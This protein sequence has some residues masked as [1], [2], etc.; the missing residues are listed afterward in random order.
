MKPV[1]AIIAHI[2]NHHGGLDQARAPQVA[3]GPG[4]KGLLGVVVTSVGR[5]FV[6]SSSLA[7][8]EPA[9]PK[10]FYSP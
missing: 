1:E 2:L 5:L 7:P 3:L 4:A 10:Q 6:V 9:R 8:R